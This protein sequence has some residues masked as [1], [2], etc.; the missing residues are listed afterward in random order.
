MQR[1]ETNAKAYD[2]LTTL[3]LVASKA[4]PNYLTSTG[5]LFAAHPRFITFASGHY[6]LPESFSYV[7][8]TKFTKRKS[9]RAGRLRNKKNMRQN[10]I[11]KKYNKIKYNN[12]N[13]DARRAAVSSSKGHQTCLQVWSFACKAEDN[14]NTLNVPK[15][16]KRAELLEEKKTFC[17]ELVGEF[18]K[19]NRAL[20]KKKKVGTAP[21]QKRRHV[22]GSSTI[23]F[24][25]FLNFDNSTKS[26]C[27]N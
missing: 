25:Y 11:T 5:R 16:A 21:A 18:N 24:A 19:P 12:N 8:T 26:S 15:T 14:T 3:N 9:L 10:K 20:A 1:Y 17:C 23:T 2:E 13:D 4:Q 7:L 22:P 6:K 27:E